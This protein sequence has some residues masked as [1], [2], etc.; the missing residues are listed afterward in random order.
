M[1]TRTMIPVVLATLVALVL[2]GGC[3]TGKYAP[4]ANEELYGTWTNEDTANID[5]IQRQVYSSGEWKDYHKLADSVP[6]D[7]TTFQID[8]KQT[9]ATGNIWYRLSCTQ[10][11]GPAAGVDFRMLSKL[12]K[13]STVLE[14]VF[15]M[16][17]PYGPISYPT[18]IDTKS[19][20]YHIFYRAGS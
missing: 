2:L 12:S 7:E 5:L 17:S 8:S 9:D 18:Q 13:S 20:T 6:V 1:K 11:T 16:S 14:Y 10:K 3:A 4:K 19:D 15:K